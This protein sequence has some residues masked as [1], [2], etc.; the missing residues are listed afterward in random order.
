LKHEYWKQTC[1]THKNYLFWAH[2]QSKGLQGGGPKGSLGVTS[3]APGSVRECEGINPHTPKGA[4]TLGIGVSV[5]FRFF[6]ERL[7]GS[8]PNE[9]KNSLYHW[10]ALGT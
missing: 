6:K 2:D 3:H 4:P 8:K 9:L 7:K 5:D 1:T 10:K